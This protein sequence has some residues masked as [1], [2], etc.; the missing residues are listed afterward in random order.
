MGDTSYLAV[1]TTVIGAPFCEEPRCAA[2]SLSS[3]CVRLIHS[4]IR[5]GNVGAA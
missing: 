1:L 5:S 2:S 4:A 3:H